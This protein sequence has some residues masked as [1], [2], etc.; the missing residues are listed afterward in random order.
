MREHE[1]GRKRVS[2]KRRDGD[3]EGLRERVELV[4][5]GRREEVRRDCK[6]EGERV[7]G[8]KW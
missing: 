6:R 1:R 5:A 7:N 8:S 2:V 4:R 3:I